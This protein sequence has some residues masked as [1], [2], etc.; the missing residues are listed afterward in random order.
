MLSQLVER[1]SA[2]W[3]H[4]SKGEIMPW[5]RARVAIAIVLAM[6]SCMATDRSLAPMPARLVNL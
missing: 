1:L 3:E 6:S 5:V 4:K 2:K